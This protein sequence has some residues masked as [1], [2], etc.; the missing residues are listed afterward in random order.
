LG[1]KFIVFTDCQALVYLNFHKTVKPQI[2]RW[3]EV[4]HEYDF[5]IKYRSCTRKAH[6]DALSRAVDDETDDVESVDKQLTE[7]L[8]VCIALTKEE[9]VRFMQQADKHSRKLIALLESGNTL[10]R[11]EKSEIENFEC[12]GY[13]TDYMKD[14]RYSLSRK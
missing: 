4:L 14:A 13:F 6:A 2:T 8:E 11:Q 3:F 5:E 12:R 10:T 9:H 7:R 1:I